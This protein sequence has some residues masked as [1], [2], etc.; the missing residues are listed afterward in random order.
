MMPPAA[1]P[2]AAAPVLD[3]DDDKEAPALPTHTALRVPLHG[4]TYASQMIHAWHVLSALAP[5]EHAARKVPALHAVTVQPR[6]CVA[7]AELEYDPAAHEA[8]GV[9]ALMSASAVPGA[10]R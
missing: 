5:W 9:A 7:P 3:D 8:H 4:D 2:P 10:H 1:A 6:H